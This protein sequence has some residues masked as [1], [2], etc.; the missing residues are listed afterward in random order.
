MP[1]FRIAILVFSPGGNTLKAA[2]MAEMKL[3]E[4]G[5]KV[6]LIDVTAAKVIKAK[7]RLH[8]FLTNEVKPHDLLMVGGPVYENRLDKLTRALIKYLPKPN[9]EKWGGLC[10]PFVS[11]GGVTSGIG[12]HQ[13]AKALR[14]SGRKVV[15]AFKV[16]A[17]HPF[18]LEWPE[19]LNEGMP[20]DEALP[21]MAE[22]AD[23]VSEIAEADPAALRDITGNLDYADFLPRFFGSFTTIFPTQ[24]YT[25]KDVKVDLE[26]C[27]GCGACACRCPLDRLEIHEG[28]ARV[29][30]GATRCMHCYTCLR[31]CPS[32]ARSAGLES[33]RGFLLALRKRFAEKPGNALYKGLN[34]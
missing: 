2:S 17:F 3:R 29:R 32:Q 21:L 15:M 26:L 7:E 6:Q 18:S 22:L 1:D 23:R 27:K 19:R 25:Y 5:F 16:E 31:V 9:G 14:A 30:D 34:K 33:T 12:L 4:R 8:D 11:W 24:Q 13:A 20:G 28:K 10:A